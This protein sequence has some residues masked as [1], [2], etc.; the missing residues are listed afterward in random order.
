MQTI[1]VGSAGTGYPGFGCFGNIE[2]SVQSTTPLP[3]AFPRVDHFQLYAQRFSQGKGQHRTEIMGPDRSGLFAGAELKTNGNSLLTLLVIQQLPQ[4]DSGKAVCRSADGAKP[5][6]ADR[7]TTTYRLV[8]RED[9]FFTEPDNVLMPCR[10]EL[11]QVAAVEG[12]CRLALWA[13]NLHNSQAIHAMPGNGR[14][15]GFFKNQVIGQHRGNHF[16]CAACRNLR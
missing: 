11:N 9:R 2:V 10:F 15:Q 12:Y 8:L 5:G 7:N 3:G 16:N 14:T 4:A 1:D 13:L 6:P